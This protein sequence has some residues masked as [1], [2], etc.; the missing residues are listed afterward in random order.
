MVRVTTPAR[1]QGSAPHGTPGCRI[2]PDVP[3]QATLLMIVCGM[4]I[5]LQIV[6]PPDLERTVRHAAQRRRLSMSAWVRQAI[7]RQLAAERPSED[8]LDRLARLDAPTAD[9]DTML[10]EIETGRA[11]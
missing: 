11:G 10:A 8:A 3:Q 9:I 4:S 6:V 7:E 1:L 2:D 5:R